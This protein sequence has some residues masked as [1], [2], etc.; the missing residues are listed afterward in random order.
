[1]SKNNQ[2][3]LEQ[4]FHEFLEQLD[5][6]ENIDKSVSGEE[7]AAGK[8][9]DFLLNKRSVIL[10]I[11][12]L[13]S[14]PEYK[15][16]EILT[17][18]RGREEFPAFFWNADLDEILPYLPDG[19]EIRL[20]IADAVTRSVEKALKKADDQI[21][22]TRQALSLPEACGV[23]VIL[24]EDINILA[25]NIVTARAS[26]LLLKKKG[27]DFRYQQISYV[28]IISE[29]HT[30]TSR[31]VQSFPLILLSG[32]SAA[33][34]NEQA[35]EYISGLAKRWAEFLG[36]PLSSCGNL[37]NFDGF[38]FEARA[39]ESEEVIDSP[40][41]HEIWRRAY[42]RNPYL[43]A[44]TE[45][46]F[47]KHGT[48]IMVSMVPNFLIGGRKSPKHKVAVLME[49]FTHVLEEAEYRRLDMRKL[50]ARLPDFST[51]VK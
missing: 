43:R 2:K 50:Q 45:D 24:N 27:T 37:E 23:A 17:P 41:V 7:L 51:L 11:K 30:V 5:G 29:R 9:A 46:E 16:E 3:S 35:S 20:K 13:E 48:S 31:A 10:E 28:W 44:L 32:P 1:M 36:A 26:K 18:Q 25:P 33:R 49:L 22:A 40:V 4:R 21:H 34:D 6:S 47:L 14:D 42:R 15:V 8:R 38:K 12:S 39:Y 19:R